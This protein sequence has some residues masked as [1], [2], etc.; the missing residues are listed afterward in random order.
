[1]KKYCSQCATPAMANMLKC[2][3][4]G[5]IS[6][7]DTAPLLQGSSTG[8]STTNQA[9]TTSVPNLTYSVSKKAASPV[10]AVN[11]AIRKTFQFSGRASRSEYWYFLLFFYVTVIGLSFLIG[12]GQERYGDGSP[13]LVFLSIVLVIFII[14][15][16]IAHLSVQVRRLHDMDNSAWWLLLMF[17]PLLSLAL[18]IMSCGRGT[19]G[20]NQY[21]EEADYS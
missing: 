7:S 5:S 16:S 8:R 17:V 6:W 13:L 2:P 15:I 4:C 21:G 20:P 14:W 10:A 3:K 19:V 1:M 12:W 9:Q 18:L 11:S